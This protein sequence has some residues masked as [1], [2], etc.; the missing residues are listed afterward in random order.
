MYV[1]VCLCVSISC[2]FTDKRKFRSV[3]Y[4]V[5]TV[6]VLTL[7]KVLKC[8]GKVFITGTLMSSQITFFIGVIFSTLF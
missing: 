2:Q 4:T 6:F 3:T 1:Y 8:S 5:D 7:Y